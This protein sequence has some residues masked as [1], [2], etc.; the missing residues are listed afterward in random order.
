MEI[1]KNTSYDDLI[2]HHAELAVAR[3][4]DVGPT[5]LILFRSCTVRNII[6][7]MNGMMMKHR[8]QLVR[9]RL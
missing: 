7:L 2:S 6:K 8:Q 4:I 3:G 5:K 1:N 9:P